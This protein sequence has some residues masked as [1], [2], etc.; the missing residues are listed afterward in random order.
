MTAV[1]PVLGKLSDIGMASCGGLLT[2]PGCADWESARRMT[3]CPTTKLASALER[4]PAQPGA[5]GGMV[6]LAL[7]RPDG[8]TVIESE[9]LAR[10]DKPIN[11]EFESFGQAVAVLH[12]NLKF[13]VQVVLAQWSRVA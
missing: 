8:A 13:T 11:Y 4:S 5:D 12:V 10:Q 9:H 6:E 7:V 2:R 3:S 1:S